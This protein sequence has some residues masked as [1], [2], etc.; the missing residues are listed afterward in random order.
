MVYLICGQKGTGKSLFTISYLQSHFKKYSYVFANFPVNFAK[1]INSTDWVKFQFPANSAILI[2]EAQLYFNSRKFSEL[3]KSGL[4][5]LLLDFLIMCRHYKVDLF[6]ITQSSNRIDLQIRELSDYVFYLRKTIKIFGRP[7]LV[8]GKE[9]VDILE[10]EKY[11]N[12]NNFSNEFSYN[13]LIKIIR[14][15]NLKAYDTNFIDKYYY[16]KKLIELNDW[17]VPHTASAVAPP[18][19]K[20]SVL[21][22]HFKFFILKLKNVFHINKSKLKENQERELN[23]YK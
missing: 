6:F 15:K 2:D 1:V 17:C 5:M 7:I 4:G 18:I 13:F 11:M 22:T 12:P 3:T 9:F 19:T 23:F 20:L 14:K 16:E 21:K 8:F 10:F